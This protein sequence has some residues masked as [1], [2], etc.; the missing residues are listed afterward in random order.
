VFDIL[1]SHGSEDVD[2]DL[3]GC[4][5]YANTSVSEEHTTSY[6]TTWH[7]NLDD[8]SQQINVLFLQ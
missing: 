2:C 3:V 8:H 4:V 6:M 5:L 1:G 7:H